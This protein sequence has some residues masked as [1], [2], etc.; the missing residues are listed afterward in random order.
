MYRPAVA[1]CPPC[2]VTG[3]G[4]PAVDHAL[5]IEALPMVAGTAMWC[6][7]LR[8]DPPPE[9]V[10][11]LF[12]GERERASRFVFAADRRRYLASH[13]A[14]RE[15][16]ASPLDCGPEFIAY[17][18]GAN[19]KPRL[20]VGELHFNMSHSQDWALIGIGGDNEIGVDVE[21]LRQLDDIDTL[22]LR[23]FTEREQR[24]LAAT[25]IS[26]RSLAFLRGWTR[27][28]ACMK[29]IGTGLSLEPSAIDAGLDANDC[30]LHVAAPG[31]HATLRVQSFDAGAG[32][33]AA[34]ARL[35][36]W[37]AATA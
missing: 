13:C 32:L 26:D 19:G 22:A 1:A 18:T 31:G 33:V 21:V 5:G 17:T 37:R 2:G 34:L 27:K 23:L 7:D 10:V 15:L 30:T 11:R 14:L 12:D 6:V 20:A 24:Q 4:S 9:R 8:H 29:A 3:D 25:P 28:E 35:G 16:L 36:E